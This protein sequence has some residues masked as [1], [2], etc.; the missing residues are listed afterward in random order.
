MTT[1]AHRQTLDIPTAWIAVS[2]SDRRASCERRCLGPASTL[3]MP[4][5]SRSPAARV[6]A[7]VCAWHHPRLSAPGAPSPLHTLKFGRRLSSLSFPG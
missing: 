7:E 1:T 3:D 2:G 6:N 4:V 5:R